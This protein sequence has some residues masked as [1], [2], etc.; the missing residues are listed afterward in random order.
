MNMKTLVGPII[1]KVT[2]TTAR[3]LLEYDNAG[4]VNVSLLV[5]GALMKSIT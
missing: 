1:G 3:I 4:E 2:D 5:N